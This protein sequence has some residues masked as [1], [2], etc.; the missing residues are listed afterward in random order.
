MVGK[1]LKLCAMVV[2]LL[3]MVGKG[4]SCFLRSVSSL[5]WLVKG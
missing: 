4:L 2:K 3:A 5:L 1:R